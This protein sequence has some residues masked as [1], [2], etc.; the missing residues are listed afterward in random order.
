MWYTPQSTIKLP[1][2][3]KSRN[4]SAAVFCS[5]CLSDLFITMHLLKYLYK[6][7][8]SFV[9]MANINTQNVVMDEYRL[10]FC[11]TATACKGICLVLN[12]TWEHPFWNT[13]Y[14]G[15]DYLMDT[16][17]YHEWHY[18]VSQA[19]TQEMLLSALPFTCVAVLVFPRFWPSNSIYM[20]WLTMKIKSMVAT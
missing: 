17:V 11:C 10:H 5:L 19:A 13:C 9:C 18:Q 8:A 7:P 14:L 3:Y 16:I 20:S 1:N 15:T 2:E 6:E 4:A 12:W